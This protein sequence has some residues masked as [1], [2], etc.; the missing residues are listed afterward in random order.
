MDEESDHKSGEENRTIGTSIDVTSISSPIS[1]SAFVDRNPS[2]SGQN[3]HHHHHNHHNETIPHSLRRTPMFLPS[4]SSSGTSTGAQLPHHLSNNLRSNHHHHHH[5]QP[6][7]QQR[8]HLS[9]DVS[10]SSH[11]HL[12]SS[13]SGHRIRSTGIEENPQNLNANMIK[14]GLYPVSDPRSSPSRSMNFLTLFCRVFFAF[15]MVALPLMVLFYFIYYEPLQGYMASPSEAQARSS[16]NNPSSQIYKVDSLHSVFVKTKSGTVQGERIDILNKE[17]DVFLGIPYAEPPIGDLRFRKPKEIK[18]WT[19]IY[20]AI[21]HSRP[22]LQYK[23]DHRVK[24]ANWVSPVTSSEDCLYL[25][26]WAAVNKKQ[27]PNSLKP[28][29]IY[30]YGGNFISG[31]SDVDMYDGGVLA[32]FGDIIVVTF[33]YRLGV[34]GFLNA[35]HESSPGNVGLHDQAAVIKWVRNNIENFGGDPD[36]I[37]LAGV[38]AGATSVG[39][40]LISPVTR[41]LFKRAILQSGSPLNPQVLEE[42]QLTVDRSQQL[43]IRV[44]CA[45]ERINIYK[46]PEDVTNCLRKLE[47]NFLA[48]AADE[49]MVGIHPPFGA[50]VGNEFLPFNPYGAIKVASELGFTKE[51]LMG[52]NK[53]EGS[54]LLHMTFPKIFSSQNPKKVSAYQVVPLIEEAFKFM[55]NPGPKLI[56]H[57]FMND[58][59]TSDHNS[60]RD[61]FYETLGDFVA[62]CPS[63]FFG[64][65][66]SSMNF[67]VYH[68]F[69]THRPSNSKWGKWMGVVRFDEVPF[70]FGMP[71]TKPH[72]YS[73]DEREFSARLMETWVNFIRH[74]YAFEPSDHLSYPS[75]L[76]QFRKPSSQNGRSWPKYVQDERKY[77]QLDPHSVDVTIGPHEHQC[78]LWRFMFQTATRTP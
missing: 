33:N 36:S 58:L 68:Y 27:Q 59:N 62:V 1:S 38:D 16:A 77:M 50:S 46:H 61:K 11:H 47:A 31:S 6:H 25:N 71:F 5:H 42:P 73:E 12:N 55:P 65:Q 40:H 76:L 19:G 34:L 41:N 64:E 10:S 74:G 53:D 20:R 9:S 28:V 35:N 2:S 37:T 49:M 52:S 15:S 23:L 44:S 26:I 78:N 43:A 75:C 72:E 30:A 32:A 8:S 67:T 45:N 7:R 69:Y 21:R 14:S 13:T 29:L 4:S 60:I 48:K 57:F 3:S 56:T 18:P 17:I 51:I 39:F 63:V 22:C 24:E 70:I 54:L 66:M